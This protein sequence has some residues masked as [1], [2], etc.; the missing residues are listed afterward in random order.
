MLAD[1]EGLFPPKRESSPQPIIVTAEEIAAAEEEEKEEDSPND[2]LDEHSEVVGVSSS[3]DIKR[4]AIKQE[5]IAI[6]RSPQKEKHNSANGSPPLKM[7]KMSFTSLKKVFISMV[8]KAN[9]L[10]QCF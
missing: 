5:S 3:N 2:N 9:H 10:H 6:S 8:K 1:K 4:A 7:R